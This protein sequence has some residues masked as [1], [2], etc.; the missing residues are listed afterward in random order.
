VGVLRA[1]N[2]A[3]VVRGYN[4]HFTMQDLARK[5]RIGV[6]RVR[7]ILRAG[8]VLEIKKGPR[9]RF[10]LEL[11]IRLH[12]DGVA[13]LAAAQRMGVDYTT[14]RKHLRAAGFGPHQHRRGIACRVPPWMSG[15]IVYCIT[16]AGSHFTKIGCTSG[17]M[18]V[19]RLSALAGGNPRTLAMT[20]VM[21]GSQEIERRLHVMFAHLRVFGGEWFEDRDRE[22]ERY[23]DSMSDGVACVRL[24]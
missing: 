11:A 20:H 3:D 15:P 12:R 6:K 9:S 19:S 13:P 16:E 24:E 18:A 21:Q 23:F 7:N 8:G 17:A 22:I 4:E 5:H 1:C 10:N 14:M 2:E